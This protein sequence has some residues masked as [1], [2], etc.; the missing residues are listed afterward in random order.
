MEL[1]VMAAFV[2]SSLTG[3]VSNK[4]NKHK[5]WIE[6]EYQGIVMEN[7]R[8]V[9]LNPPLFAIDKD[10]P[11][12]YAG[13]ICGF[14]IHGQNIPFEAVV[15]DKMTG[16]GLIRAK[17]PVDC[18]SQKEHTF[19]IQAHDCGEAPERTNMKRSH[20]ALVRVRVN[21]V[22][23]FVPVFVER[24]YQV[25][26]GEGKMYERVLKVEAVDGD[27]SP[28]YSQICFYEILTPGIPFTID[29]DGNI[30]NT[31]KLEVKKQSLHTFTVTAYDC[32]K[33]RAAEDAQVEVLVKPTCRPAWQGWN[34]RIEYVPGSRSKALFPHIRLETCDE[35]VWNVEVFVELQTSHVAKGCDRDNYSERTLRKLC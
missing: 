34:K 3:C 16:E 28:Q 13:E 22:N 4:A 9:L 29:N 24:R 17:E 6:T 1:V 26:V 11:L 31:E 33:K 25:S 20:K 12:H 18:E 7:D 14:K 2:L 5:P 15:L 30:R 35:A 27:C 32:G 23:E 21:D 8:T 19:T 10:A